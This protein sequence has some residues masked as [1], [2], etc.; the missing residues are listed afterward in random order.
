MKQNIKFSAYSL[1]VTAVVLILCVVGIFSLI[2]NAEKL[3]LFC[4]IVCLCISSC[5]LEKRVSV[6]TGRYDNIPNR[7]VQQHYEIETSRDT[8]ATYRF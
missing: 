2:G 7:H 5:S 3:T 4:I 6:T 1:I 8:V